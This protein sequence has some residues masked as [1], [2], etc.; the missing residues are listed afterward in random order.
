[1]RQKDP[2]NYLEDGTVTGIVKFSLLFTMQKRMKP[3]V[4]GSLLWTLSFLIMPFL[5]ANGYLKRVP[6]AVKHGGELPEFDRPRKLLVQG[7][8]VTVFNGIYVAVQ[9]ALGLPAYLYPGAVSFV[10]SG[11]SVGFIFYLYLAML[12]IQTEEGT[13]HTYTSGWRDAAEKAFT[14]VYLRAMVI[15]V[16]SVIDDIFILIIS[17]HLPFPLSWLLPAFFFY[18]FFMYTYSVAP[19]LR[20][21]QTGR[22]GEIRN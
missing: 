3:Y 13:V 22:L 15:Y 12:G 16:V 7:I 17:M 5:F 9:A 1:M 18:Y 10:F 14:W 20:M 11:I 4:A 19:L 2:Y 8:Q 21:K 6:E